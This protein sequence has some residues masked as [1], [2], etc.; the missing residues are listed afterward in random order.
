MSKSIHY[1]KLSILKYFNTKWTST[2]LPS[3]KITMKLVYF[4]DYFSGY[5][6]CCS[7][8]KLCL[9]LCD[10]LDCMQHI[11]LTFTVSQSLLKFMSIESVMLS[12]HMYFIIVTTIS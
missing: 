12:N 11:R 7:V 2:I 8:T 10:P 3:E 5:T 1:K 4:S 6:F 9:T